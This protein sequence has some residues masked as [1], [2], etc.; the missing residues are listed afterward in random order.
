VRVAAAWGLAR[1]A[2][3]S[4]SEALL[5]CAETHADWER[6]NETDACVALAE[7]L[8]AAGKKN[9]ARA[10]YEHLVKTRTDP[11]ERHVRAAAERGLAE[12]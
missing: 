11:A 10:I 12:V 9:E 6:I 8:V 2:D 7:G 3:A 4:A 1:V 5:K